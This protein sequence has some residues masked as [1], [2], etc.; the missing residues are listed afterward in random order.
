MGEGSDWVFG[1]GWRERL[2]KLT[3]DIV[4]ECLDRMLNE[5]PN[6]EVGGEFNNDGVIR[7]AI[8]GPRVSLN[9]ISE[10]VW[11]DDLEVQIIIRCKKEGDEES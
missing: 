7:V 8:D 3:M 4:T 6:A 2:K 10:S 1:P 11:E 9:V 5:L